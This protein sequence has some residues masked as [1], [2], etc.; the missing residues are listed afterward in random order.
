MLL[1][2]T[3]HVNAKIFSTV[4]QLS[5]YFCHS[6]SNFRPWAFI[7]ILETILT[8]I[9]QIMTEN[10]IVTKIHRLYSLLFPLELLFENI[11]VKQ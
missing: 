9:K 11:Q 1:K 7:R 5:M 3:S 2:V 4:K 8:Q 6:L 10:L